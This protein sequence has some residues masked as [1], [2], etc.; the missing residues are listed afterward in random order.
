MRWWGVRCACWGWGWRG[1]CKCGCTRG[2]GG[3]WML[4]VGRGMPVAAGDWTLEDGRLS[5][6]RRPARAGLRLCTSGQQL[7]AEAFGVEAAGVGADE[8][9]DLR[10]IEVL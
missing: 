6:R 4:E 3:W 8:V 9:L 2:W 10:L 1:G 7:L 5:A